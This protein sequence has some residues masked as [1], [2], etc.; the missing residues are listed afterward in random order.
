MRGQTI[1]QN[2]ETYGSYPR[3]YYRYL[4]SLDYSQWDPISSF[5]DAGRE[6]GLEAGLWYTIMEDD[7]GGHVKSDFLKA[8][9]ELR[10]VNRKGEAVDG[11]LEFW[12]EPVREYKLAI[13]DELLKKGAKHILLDLVRR[14]G[15]PSSDVDG[16]YQYGFNPQIVS[17]FRKQ[18][19]LDPRRLSPGSA[20]WHHWVDFMSRPY[21]DFLIEACN[22]INAHKA[23]AE[24]MTWPVHLKTW[25]AIDLEKILD[26]GS[27]DA[28]H[29][30]SHAYSYSPADLDRQLSSL[31]PQV[32]SRPVKIVPSICGYEGLVASGLDDFFAAAQDRDIHTL[33]LHESESLLRNRMSTRFRAMAFGVPHFKRALHSR[34]ASSV[35]WSLATKCSGFLRGYNESTLETDQLTEIQVAHTTDEL[36][37][38]FTCHERNVSALLPVPSWPA[39]NYNVKQLEARLWWNPKE[40]VHL[41]LSV[42]GQF[43]DYFHFLLDPSNASGQ[44][45]RLSERWQGIWKHDVEIKPS[46]WCANFRIPFKTL[47]IHPEK[48]M[49]IAIHAVRAQANPVQIT[50]L[51]LADTTI[52]NPD[53]FGFLFLD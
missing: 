18:T 48:G 37:V 28:V 27:I 23:S 32:R 33:V 14:N 4:E 8:H 10:C 20:E 6:K 38:R 42:P 16:F 26:A 3:S 2:Y 12:F 34:Q 21:T 44:E 13:L 49:K 46:A 11:C 5:L 45:Q 15:T 35:D 52:L 22:R 47:G 43:N 51:N 25:M 19:G 29:V 24:L 53:E 1:L 7:H 40:S 17:A 39:D 50:M 36:C 9:P 41:F 30:A 31:Q